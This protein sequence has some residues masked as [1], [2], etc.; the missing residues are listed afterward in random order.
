MS[1]KLPWASRIL[2]RT[3]KGHLFSGEYSKNLVSHTVLVVYGWSTHLSRDIIWVSRKLWNMESDYTIHYI[4]I[5]NHRKL[6]RKWQTTFKFNVISFIMKVLFFHVKKHSHG[7]SGWW[8]Q[9][10]VNIVTK[11]K[12]TTF[13]FLPTQQF[14]P[15]MQGTFRQNT[16]NRN[17]LAFRD[18][19]KYEVRN[20]NCLLR[21]RSRINFLHVLLDF[22]VAMELATAGLILG[23]HSANERRCYFVTMSLIGWAKT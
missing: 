20:G 11:H 7:Y 17:T 15:T 21:V 3:D 9:I 16:C 14:S 2:H 5:D 10:V 19:E 22:V 13:G 4:I 6:H 12:L 8:E 23:L 18:G 1:R